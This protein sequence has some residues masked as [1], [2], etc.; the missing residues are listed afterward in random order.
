[1]TAWARY[2]HLGRNLDVIRLDTWE[3]SA[4][5]SPTVAVTLGGSAPGIAGLLYSLARPCG[6]VEI[7]L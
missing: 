3:G 4:V 6:V 2:G 7:R 1:M 5:G